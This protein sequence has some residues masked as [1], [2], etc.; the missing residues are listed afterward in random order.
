MSAYKC[1]PTSCLENFQCLYCDY[2]NDNTMTTLHN[3]DLDDAHVAL[4]CI[5]TIATLPRIRELEK[6]KGPFKD[7]QELDFL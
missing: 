5:L 2:R 6:E 7:Y 4:A 3:I 1:H